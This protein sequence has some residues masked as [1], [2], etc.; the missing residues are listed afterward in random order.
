MY[1]ARGD[2]VNVSHTYVVVSSS[3]SYVSSMF[4]TVCMLHWFFDSLTSGMIL[5]RWGGGVGV[6]GRE[7]RRLK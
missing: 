7:D 3:C 2:N 5:E 6:I 4:P 1:I